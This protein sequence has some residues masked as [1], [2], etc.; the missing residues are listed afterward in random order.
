MLKHFFN[1]VLKDFIT[2]ID[3]LKFKD[4]NHLQNEQNMSSNLDSFQTQIQSLLSNLVISPLVSWLQNEKKVDVTAEELFEALR[5]PKTQKAPTVVQPNSLQPPIPLSTLGTFTET[6]KPVPR[7]KSKPKQSQTTLDNYS[8]TTCKYTFQ[9]GERKGQPCGNPVNNGEE[10]CT[11]CNK[12][13][14]TARTSDSKKTLATEETTGFS[15]INVP[16]RTEEIKKKKKIELREISSNTYLDVQTN[17]V[18]KK[19][20]DNENTVY[21]AIGVQEEDAFRTLKEDEKKE[22]V[23]RGFTLQVSSGDKPKDKTTS[24]IPEIESDT[25]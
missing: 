9:R 5:I 16:K 1:M 7:P 3:N 21:V 22:A 18:V 13:T 10:Y 25:E 8:G 2:K 14:K 17:F 23:S 24:A 15:S 12:K 20:V 19:V 4:V 11:T 6:K